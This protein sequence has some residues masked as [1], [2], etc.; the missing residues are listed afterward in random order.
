MLFRSMYSTIHKIT[1]TFLVLAGLL[2]PCVSFSQV[3]NRM[4]V[5]TRP[6]GMGGAFIAVSDD[7]NALYWNPAGLPFLQRQEITSM[8]SNPYGGQLG[9]S[10]SY[11]GY[12]FPLS[13]RQGIGI[14]W[15]HFGLGD[16]EL[17][18]RRDKFNLSY[19][20][21]PHKMVSVGLNLKIVDSDMSLDN[22]SIGKAKGYGFDFGVI[23][24]PLPRLRLGLVGYDIG[25]TSVRYD[26][27]VSEEILSQQFKLGFAYQA[28]E[29]M[30]ITAD[31]GD[32]FHLGSE[33][34]LLGR[35]ALRAGIQKSI[36]KL[37]NYAPGMMFSGGFG[38]KY[39][40]F[41]L[42][43]A[44]LHHPDLPNTHMFSISFFY[45]PSLVSIKSAEIKPVPLFRS[46]YR[47]YEE[48]EFAEVI[49]KNAGQ[50]ELPVSVSLD[51]PTLMETPAEVNLVLPPQ[52]TESY[53]LKV[54]FSP[55]IL[56]A[57][58][59]PYDN[60]VQPVIKV[61]YLQDRQ[62]KE[63]SY[64]LNPV[65]IL[66]KG[67]ISW[68]KLNR[69]GAFVT[70]VDK[71][72]DKFSRSIIQEYNDVIRDEY[73]NS[74]LGRA[75]VLFDALG[76]YGIVYQADVKTPWFKIAQDSTIFDNIQ[77]PS[78]LLRSKIGDCD[79]CTVLFG[80][81]LENLGIDTI[82]LDVSAPGAGHIF[83]MFDSGISVEEAPRN[84]L[85]ES[86]YVIYEGRV[87]IPVEPTMF[88]FTFADAWRN[89]SEEY[90]KRKKQGYLTEI[91][92]AKAKVEYQA[93]VVP[94][95]DIVPPSREIIDEL[96][97]MDLSINKERF[98]QM[99]QIA[100]V[101]FDSPEGLY[102][103]GVTYLNFNRLDD[104]EESLK[105][106][107]ELKPG[108]ADAL[109]ALGVVY[110][111]KRQY[112]QAMEYYNRALASEPDSP[113]FNLNIAIT[114]YLQGKLNEA[115]GEYEKVIKK[116]NDYE[117]M[118]EFLKREK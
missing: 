76:K 22:N 85:T 30:I 79:D 26:N 117:G 14:D 71:T 19:A 64:N 62:P 96:V 2:I 48:D 82:F 106:A 73:N 50:K 109:N 90:H 32:R 7:A 113:L 81:L 21:R 54:T 27:E 46:F 13:D 94:T 38:F 51:V 52:S 16:D 97:N 29:N 56:A 95:Q 55:E 40:F 24:T 70:P 25:G 68:S 1:I 5:G 20:V 45:N 53:P 89:A 77:Y 36:K 33:Y 84:F 31:I 99:T 102:Q 88:G 57:E 39:R 15:F 67:K 47:K 66:G 63:A 83:L 59:A 91:D 80:S 108:F 42:D 4:E 118:L 18:Y 10:N 74:N 6:L 114:L 60:L 93:G 112:N 28:L 87:W 3:N 105:K 92:V 12:V 107:I 58:R 75:V 44:Y 65:Y 35:L 23:V 78:E 101:S 49:L 110:T 116:D 111:M 37:D 17:N 98:Q 69:V 104:A 9:M 103:A 43:Y 11:L 86:E 61:T 72:V 115:K 41:Q 34:W 100:G 8:Y